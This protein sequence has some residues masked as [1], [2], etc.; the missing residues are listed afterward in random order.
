MSFFRRVLGDV[1]ASTSTFSASI[2][3]P[4]LAAWPCTAHA[5]TLQIIHTNDLHSFLES[6]Q[7]EGWG[8]YAAVKATIEKIRADADRQR[9]VTLANAYREAQKI[10]GEGDAKAAAI[11]AQAYGKNP[12]FYAFWRSMEAYKQTFRNKSDVMVLDP[13]SEF[14]K[15]FKNA[16]PK[17]R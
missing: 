15:Y 13:S 5:K 1:I 8:G 3:L 6:S 2:I 17:P 14:F 11:Y 7:F 16:Q 10:K 4:L 9:E 12:E